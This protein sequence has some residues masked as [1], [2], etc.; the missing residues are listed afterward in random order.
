M[1]EDMLPFT[2]LLQNTQAWSSWTPRGEIAPAF[3][4]DTQ[5][6]IGDRPALLISG[7]NNALSCGCWQMPLPNLQ[8]G[9]HY[10]IEAYFSTKG[11]LAPGKSVRAILTSG[12]DAFY[13]HLDCAPPSA[14]WHR[15]RYDWQHD[16]SVENLTVRLFLAWSA[17]GVVRWSDV[18]LF[19]LT[20]REAPESKT[21]RFAAV[22][23]NPEKP[24]SPAL[25]LDFYAD[26]IASI[27]GH[28]DLVCLPELINTTGL[29]G[30]PVDWAE[31]IPGPT[32]ER[33]AEIA[34]DRG[35]YLA[36]SML[37]RQG[38]AVYN[39]G[40]LIDRN[41]GLVG[42]YRKV[43]LTMGEG[44]LRGFTPGNELP[45]FHTDFGTVAYMICYDGHYPEVPRLLALKGAQVILFSNMNDAREGGSVWESVVRTRAVDNQVHIVAAVNRARSCIVSPKGEVLSMTDQT[46]GAIAFAECDLQASLCDYSKRPIYKRYDQLRRTDLFGGLSEHI[47][48]EK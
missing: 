27:G 29:Q 16:A 30:D 46:P 4:V 1:P 23:G 36:A 17:K 34:H 18:R 10:R 42:K 15:V 35:C 40:L 44:L 38:Q 48:D 21:V 37:E 31:P 25:C 45:V 7:D 9:H 5:G 3:Q 41:G 22:S 13:A 26:R 2:D 11:V 8:H 20:G 24:T 6:G 33:L 32:S 43:Q 39:T 19:D 28:V 47:W 14:G 12:K